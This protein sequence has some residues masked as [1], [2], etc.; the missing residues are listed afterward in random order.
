MKWNILRSSFSTHASPKT[1]NLLFSLRFSCK[2]SEEYL[3]D[4]VWDE[5]K[6]KLEENHVTVI[7]MHTK[8]SDIC[9]YIK[10]IPGK[11]GNYPIPAEA[12]LIFMAYSTG[13]I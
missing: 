2:T 10:E 13:S 1:S 8:F 9:D 11:E 7:N 4:P 6:P 12:I 5:L 3:K